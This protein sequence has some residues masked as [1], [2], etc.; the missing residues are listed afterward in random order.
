VGEVGRRCGGFHP[1]SERNN[2]DCLTMM[3]SLLRAE[4]GQ[5]GGGRN[6]GRVVER[7]APFYRGGGE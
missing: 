4:S 7:S 6:L 5:N 3:G 1:V 2:D